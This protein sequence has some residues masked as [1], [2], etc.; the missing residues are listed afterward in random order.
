[1]KISI[2]SAEKRALFLEIYHIKTFKHFTADVGTLFGM[3]LNFLR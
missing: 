2:Y 3:P 1:M